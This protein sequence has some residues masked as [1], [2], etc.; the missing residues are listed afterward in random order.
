MASRSDNRK[1]QRSWPGLLGGLSL[2]ILFAA[3]M[4]IALEELSTGEGEYRRTVW[5]RLTGQPA[6]PQG[7]TQVSVQLA[8]EVC[9]QRV[10]AQ[11]GPELLQSSF[12]ERSSRYNSH[13]QVHTVFLDLRVEG[14]ERDDIY[15]RC[16]V[17]AVN[18][19]ILEYRLQNYG[20]IFWG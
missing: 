15:A 16:D 7:R 5:D 14:R 8:V 20:S 13:L 2:I 3:A 10:A 4:G 12:D 11:L 17:S 1:K 9:R 19:L 18:R 6:I